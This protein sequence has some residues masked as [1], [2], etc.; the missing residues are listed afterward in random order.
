[1]FGPNARKSSIEN[2]GKKKDANEEG[3]LSFDIRT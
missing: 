3:N 2:C 1:M